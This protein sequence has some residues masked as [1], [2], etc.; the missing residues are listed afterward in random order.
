M[1]KVTITHGFA[2]VLVAMAV[3]VVSGQESSPEAREA[4]RVR[5][6][7]RARLEL[8]RSS[9]LPDAARASGG[10]YRVEQDWNSWQVATGLD[11]LF[12]ASDVVI[13]GKLEESQP[14]LS[15]DQRA[16]STM[17]SF[18]TAEVL[19]GDVRLNQAVLVWTPGGS[20]TLADGMVVDVRIKDW[21]PLIAGQRCVLFLSA[22]KPSAQAAVVGSVSGTVLA[23]TLGRQGVFLIAG[24]RVSVRGRNIDI[25]QQRYSQSEVGKF[26]RELR[27]L[28]KG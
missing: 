26:M 28:K 12:E 15:P 4:R 27:A 13:V 24:E 19:K 21:D 11:S 7:A 18:R 16:V 9:T 22:M 25:V 3:S 8:A 20:V 2:A 14:S 23:P 6:A 5:E 1:K 17:L 10:V